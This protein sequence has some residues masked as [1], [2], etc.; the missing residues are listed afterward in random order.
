LE[1][2]PQDSQGAGVM[3]VLGE[4]SHINPLIDAQP[5]EEPG[6]IRIKSRRLFLV[7]ITESTKVLDRS[8]RREVLKINEGV[9]S[10]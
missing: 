10:Y 5:R 1:N 6:T 8:R 4:K 7:E 2:G 9:G 3:V